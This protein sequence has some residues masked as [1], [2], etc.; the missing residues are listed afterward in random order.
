VR[1][2]LPPLLPWIALTL[3]FLLPPAFGIFFS[4]RDFVPYF[5][6]LKTFAVAE[7]LGGRVPWWSPFNGC[8]E[9]FLTNPQAGLLYPPTWLFVLPPALAGQSYQFLHLAAAALGMALLARACGRGPAFS[10]AVGFAYGFS[11]PMLS[12]WDLPFNLGTMAWFPWVLWGVK[13]G[14]P[15]AAGTALTLGFLAGEP[16]LWAAQLPLLALFV[17]AEGGRLG[18]AARGALAALPAVA[19]TAAWLAVGYADSARRAGEEAARAGLW[20][21]DWAAAL[22]GPVLGLPFREPPAAPHDL[23]LPLPYLG[24]GLLAFALHGWAVRGRHRWYLLPALFYALLAMGERGPLGPLM[25]A[26]L[27][28]AV[29]FPARFLLLVPPCLALLALHAGGRRRPLLALVGMAVLGGWAAGRFHPLLLVPPLALGALALVPWRSRWLAW[30]VLA[31]LLA[32]GAAL[33]FPQRASVLHTGPAER[34]GTLHRL[35][36]PP[37]SAAFL[38]WAYPGG[39]FTRESDARMLLSGTAYG[40]LFSRTPVTS[41]P[42]PLKGR[43]AAGPLDDDPRAAG[44]SARPVLTAGE[45]QWE[46]LE[47]RPI[48]E[49]PPEAIRWTGQGLAFPLPSGAAPCLLRFTPSRH[50]RVRVEGAAVPWRAAGPWM[51]FEVPPGGTGRV[52]VTFTPGWAVWAYRLSALCWA[53]LLCYAILEWTSRSRRSS[54]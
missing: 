3:L 27:L 8:G 31:D 35:H 18:T 29:R 19:G 24:A 20:G 46:S 25:D 23:Y 9:L 33:C 14:R 22:A 15:A 17:W 13:G 28:S 2:K 36:V 30:V 44:A 11:G 48:V 16:V 37:E 42:H 4:L 50:V 52:E 51:A 43:P 53:A 6:P 32:V 5:L 1:S 38:R 12:C 54:A 39:R 41:T 49:P 7:T 10:A 21:R 34:P 45:L 47:G 26:P 40:N